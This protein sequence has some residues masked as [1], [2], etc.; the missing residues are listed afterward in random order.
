[1]TSYRTARKPGDRIRGN[2]LLKDRRKELRHSMT[3]AECALWELLKNRKFGDLKFRRQHGIDNFIVDFYCDEHKLIVEIDGDVHDVPEV[4]EVDRARQ[5]MLE[6]QGYH[7]V[8]ATNSEIFMEPEVVLARI[9]QAVP[10]HLW[11]G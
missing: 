1:M 7:I 11:R 2:P 5:H 10:L 8:R 6:A 9:K 3:P 4:A